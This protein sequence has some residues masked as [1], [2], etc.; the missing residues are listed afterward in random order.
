FKSAFWRS[1]MLDYKPFETWA[2]E[3]GR[4]TMALGSERVKSLLN[5]YQEPAIDPAVK[6]AIDDFVAKKKA[7][8]P[9][10]FT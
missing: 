7:S 4:D 8:M 5:A 2:E 10:A 3:G 9:D 6:E 1:E